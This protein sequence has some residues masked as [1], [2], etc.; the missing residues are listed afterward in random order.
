MICLNLLA[1]IKNSVIIDLDQP[2]DQGE[3]LNCFTFWGHTVGNVEHSGVDCEIVTD[4]ED[5]E[6]E[7]YDFSFVEGT[8]KAIFSKPLMESA[9]FDK[10]EFEAAVDDVSVRKGHTTARLA[11]EKLTGV[12][13]EL[14]MKKFDV[15]FPPGY[16]LSQRVFNHPTGVEGEYI[17]A[18]PQL[19][20]YR[21][22]TGYVNGEGAEIHTI[23]SRISWKFTNLAVVTEIDTRVDR[24]QAMVAAMYRGL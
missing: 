5:Y 20:A 6:K 16:K 10:T 15:I 21:K 13:A 9:Y 14:R 17:S 2:G 23:R 1:G 19:I 22:D 3:G 4:G 24:G 7:L 8:N 11:Y 18:V 12:N